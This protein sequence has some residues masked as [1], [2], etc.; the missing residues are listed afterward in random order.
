MLCGSLHLALLRKG[1]CCT[2]RSSSGAIYPLCYP[3]REVENLKDLLSHL[4]SSLMFSFKGLII[5]FSLVSHIKRIFDI[6]T[7]VK[8][9]FKFIYWL[10]VNCYLM[11]KSQNDYPSF[12]FF[13]LLIFFVWVLICVMS[14]HHM[15]EVP[16]KKRRRQISWDKE[17]CE[18]PCGWWELNFH[19]LESIKCS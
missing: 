13:K 16:V 3:G 5:A 7:D 14:G 8:L 1:R 19:L 12:I 6:I 10:I 4:D 11:Y 9:Y 17:G 18:L 15:H 2:L